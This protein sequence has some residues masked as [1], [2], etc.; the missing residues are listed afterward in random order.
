VFYNYVKNPLPLWRS[1]KGFFMSTA[2]GMVLRIVSLLRV[3]S[4]TVVALE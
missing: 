4:M 2:S 1:G 3:F